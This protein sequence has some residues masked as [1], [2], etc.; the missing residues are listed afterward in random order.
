[1]SLDAG[2][3]PDRVVATLAEGRRI[4]AIKALREATG[5]GLQDAM[6]LIERRLRDDV[7]LRAAYERGRREAVA[8]G[9]RWAVVFLIVALAIFLF[10]R[11]I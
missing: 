6:E 11:R 10:V 7:A 4:E 1:M 8:P 9:L 5:I 3:L 2:N